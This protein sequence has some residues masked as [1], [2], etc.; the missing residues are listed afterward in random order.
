MTPIS[1]TVI[2]TTALICR[3]SVDRGYPYTTRE[4]SRKMR[5]PQIPFAAGTPAAIGTSRVLGTHHG[6]VTTLQARGRPPVFLFH[7]RWRA[8]KGAWLSLIAQEHQKSRSPEVQN[9]VVHLHR[10][11][12]DFFPF[13][14]FFV[15]FQDF[16]QFNLDNIHLDL[17]LLHSS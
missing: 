11:P 2:C 12:V 6:S 7:N 4:T 17:I 9:P 15:D 8:G 10:E 1:I 3:Q 16:R 13:S 5:S 14:S